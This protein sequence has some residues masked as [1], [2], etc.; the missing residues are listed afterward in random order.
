MSSHSF[1]E[2]P[3][4]PSRPLPYRLSGWVYFTYEGD[5]VLGIHRYKAHFEDGEEVEG[6]ITAMDLSGRGLYHHE[7]FVDFLK[8]LAWRRWEA[9]LI[10]WAAPKGWRE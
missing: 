9:R 1:N 8:Q 2:A 5:P 10:Y 4:V 3:V 6:T 7:V